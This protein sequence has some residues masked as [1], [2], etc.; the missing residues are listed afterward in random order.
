[1]S[2]IKNKDI[3]DPSQ[4]NPLQ[5]IL[6]VLDLMDK[7][8]KQSVSVSQKLEKALRDVGNTGTGQGAKDL[9]ITTT[10]LEAE[11]K[12]LLAVEKAKLDIEKQIAVQEAKY[13]ELEKGKA[14]SL[15]EIKVKTQ[16][17]NKEELEKAQLKSKTISLYAKESAE[18]N[19][20][21]K[22]YKDL[23]LQNKENTKEGR[24]LLQNITQLDTKL[25]K[26]DATVGQFQRN[27]G[28]YTS[29]FSKFGATLK[30]IFLGGGIIAGITMLATRLSAFGK[31]ALDLGAQM[32]GTKRAFDDLN[33]PTLLDNLRK[34][35]GGTITDLELMK[36]T[37]DA[38]DFKIN[39]NNLPLYF[40]YARKEVQETGGSVTD[41][42]NKLVKGIG[43]ES[44]KVLTELGISTK[45]FNEQLK[46]TPDYV[47]AVN[48][49]I[50]ERMIEAGTYI[51]TASDVTARWSARWDNFKASA[52]GVL[53]KVLTSISP[54]LEDIW[55]WL[56][57]LWDTSTAFLLDFINGWI[58]L[59]NESTLFRITIESLQLTFTV[60]Y[61][62]VK[63]FFNFFVDN[64][65]S[66]GRLIAYTFNPKNWGAGFG[67]GL[68][69][70][71]AKNGAEIVGDVKQAGKN[72]GKAFA[73]GLK[74]AEAG[75]L[76]L[77]TKDDFSFGSGS[78]N[79]TGKTPVDTL[80]GAV[81]PEI[82][83]EVKMLEELKLSKLEFDQAKI[84]GDIEYYKQKS[85]LLAENYEVEKEYNEKTR[86]LLKD[87]AEYAGEQLGFLVASGKL[88]AK[89]FAK[90]VLDIGL[91]SLENI[92]LIS[93]ATIWAEQLKK[94][95]AGIA[96][97]AILTGLVKGVFAG[98]RS[99]IQ[100]FAEG[101][102]YVNGPGT[103]TS[104]SISARLSKGERVIPANINKQ[105]AGLKNRDLPKILNA[106][107]NTLRME[108]L[109]S[110]VNENTSATAQYLSFGKNYWSDGKYNYIQDL[111]TG[112]I[113][114]MI[115]N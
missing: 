74:D 31:S 15:A 65:K 100:S 110:N 87:T 108:S 63:L 41:L 33:N 25:K 40:A 47:T 8:I 7:K 97:A 34:A 67:K 58:T 30:N 39:L 2:I 83:A 94:G 24:A 107:I 112:T 98:V 4:G 54:V 85:E 21:R 70:I 81:K 36:S 43:K 71:L 51:E 42:V 56:G 68:A 60:L 105:L 35:T 102:E 88:S 69:E 78:K 13:V 49:I 91:K 57:K 53:D 44:K 18:L 55:N 86:E 12:K 66:T 5:P 1:M 11:T 19:K 45:D 59:Y 113:K 80:P 6:D 20:L 95:F 14:A 109:L 23:A 3:Y 84:Q 29:A 37:L 103:E 99:R 76:R 111:N 79:T 32:S 16:Q 61:E 64:L 48:T 75:K 101:T 89:E 96:T 114:R 26:V 52:G 50:K 115:I 17:L 72:I 46:L 93:I 22:Q 28:N 104:D 90:V 27:V 106:G 92:L 82:D 62:T 73:D 38:D 10:Q 9:I 77:L